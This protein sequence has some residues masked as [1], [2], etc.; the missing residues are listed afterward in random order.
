MGNGDFNMVNPYIRRI[1]EQIFQTKDGFVETNIVNNA[2]MC[3][4]LD[5]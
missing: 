4:N 2:K 5:I 3:L 1:S